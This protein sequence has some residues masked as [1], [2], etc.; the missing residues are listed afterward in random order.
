MKRIGEVLIEDS[1]RDVADLDAPTLASQMEA[2]S[3]SQPNLL[4]FVMATCEELSSET[5]ELGVFLFFVVCR[6]FERAR[7]GTLTEVSEDRILAAEERTEEALASLGAPDE[8]LLETMVGMEY[9]SQP[10][11]IQYVVEV[12]TAYGEEEGEAQLS[13]EEE[14]LLFCALSTVIDV[15]DEDSPGC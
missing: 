12:L 15:L 6:I 8:D 3:R 2:L 4:A 9:S 11:L 14:W 1:C 13:G 10:E 5:A 7:G